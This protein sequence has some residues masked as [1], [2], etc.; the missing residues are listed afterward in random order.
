MIFRLACPVDVVAAA[1]E[2]E[3]EHLFS[4]L[5]DADR[6]GRHFFVAERQLCDW[7]Y[8]KLKLSGR[9]RGHLL[10]VQEQY[11][12]RQELITRSLALVNVVI[13]NRAISLVEEDTFE[14]GHIVLLNGDY[15]ARKVAF[16]LEDVDSDAALYKQIFT[17]LASLNQ[18][19]PFGFEAVHGG[20]AG[21]GRVFEAEVKKN[22]VVVC[23]VDNDKMAPMDR[24][25]SSAR[26]VLSNYRRRNVD[27][28]RHNECFIGLAVATV[29]KEL[30]NYIPLSALRHVPEYRLYPHYQ[31]VERIL[32]REG[33]AGFRSGFWLY[34]DIK[35]G[36]NGRR[37]VEKRQ[38]DEVSEEVVE[39]ICQ[40]VGCS[41][42]ELDDVHVQGLGDR[43]VATFLQCN[44][45]LA[46]F[47]RTVR[48]EMWSG[49]FAGYFERILWFLV[50]P[51]PVRT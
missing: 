20:G 35:S 40:K 33:V 46:E 42:E 38:N 15:L 44:E 36:L 31:M 49:A 24:T 8:R 37:V 23:L 13:G 21:I 50:A 16:V 51:A 4:M 45:A 32:E 12:S 3:I 17:E 18:L 26:A 41:R 14:V 19:P 6:V 34:F 27:P 48:G 22:I 39:W 5:L 47:H 29:G 43:V 30:E 10:S 2:E 11:A 25:S 7:A 9:D 28:D 1:P